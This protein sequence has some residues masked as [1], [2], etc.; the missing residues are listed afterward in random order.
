MLLRRVKTPAAYARH[1]AHMIVNTKGIEPGME[2][3]VGD[4]VIKVVTTSAFD[5]R[6]DSLAYR[7]LTIVAMNDAAMGDPDVVPSAGFRDPTPAEVERFARIAD[8]A[9]IG[10]MDQIS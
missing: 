4:D 6:S 1:L 10:L 7:P 9:R 2:V 3:T 5:M 8:A